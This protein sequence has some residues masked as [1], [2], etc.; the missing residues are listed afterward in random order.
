MSSTTM[1][2]GFEEQLYD[3]P[4]LRPHLVVCLNPLENY[5]LLHECALKQYPP[6]LVS[7]TQTLTPTWGDLSHPS[8]R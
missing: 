7:L 2:S 3:R 1:F 5:V 4:V 6:P 8:K